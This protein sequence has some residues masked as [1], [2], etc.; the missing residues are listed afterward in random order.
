VSRQEVRMNITSTGTFDV[1]RN[2]TEMGDLL[3]NVT[4][5]GMDIENKFMKASVIEKVENQALGNMIDLSA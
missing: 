2:V 3:K 1:A 4:N 5:A